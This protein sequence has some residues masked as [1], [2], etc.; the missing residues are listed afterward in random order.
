MKL[1]V[2]P[3]YVHLVHRSAYMGPCR[4]GTWEQLERSYDEMMAAENFAKM[5]ERAWRRST[6]ARRTSAC[7]S[8]CTWSF[9]TSSWCG[10]PTL[11]R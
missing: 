3:V 10:S 8:R 6:A 5:K 2:K 4:G 11:K 7:K 9:W 1:N